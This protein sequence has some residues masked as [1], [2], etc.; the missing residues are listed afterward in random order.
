L[1][2]TGTGLARQEA[3]G[4]VVVRVWNRTKPFFRSKPGP[5]AGY[6]DPL[7]TLGDGDGGNGDCGDDDGGDGDGVD[8]DGGDGDGGDGDGG[9][10]DGGDGDGGDGVGG[11]GDGG[12]GEGVDGDGGDGDG[13]GGG[14]DN[15]KNRVDRMHSVW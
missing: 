11:N 7:L 8:D 9:D 10:D 12:D 3:L 5:L 15:W 4:Q 6:P 2:G 13:G 1:T 14:D